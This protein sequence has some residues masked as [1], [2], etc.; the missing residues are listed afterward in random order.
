VS[1]VDDRPSENRYQH[2]HPLNLVK[3]NARTIVVLLVQQLLSQTS[4]EAEAD[5]EY[6]YYTPRTFQELQ[7]ENSVMMVVPQPVQKRF[8]MKVNK[9][10]K[11]PQI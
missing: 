8:P 7:L 5:S 2:L 10:Y 11:T 4:L 1:S 3:Q 9:S 6:N